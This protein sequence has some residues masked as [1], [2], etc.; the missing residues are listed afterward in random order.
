V[1]GHGIN[2]LGHG[3]KDKFPVL[4]IAFPVSPSEIPCSGTQG[5]LSKLREFST[6][7]TG[8]PRCK[9]VGFVN[10]PVFFP[11]SREF[12]A[13]TGSIWT[14]SP[15]SQSGLQAVSLQCR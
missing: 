10:F 7:L 5:I 14:A 12:G 1:L 15:A 11:V 13:E 9:R 2:V 8:I 6:L 3:I 4:E